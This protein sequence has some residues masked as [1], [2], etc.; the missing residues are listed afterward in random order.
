ML[1]DAWRDEPWVI[2]GAAVRAS[3]VCFAPSDNELKEH[4]LDGQGVD[5]IYTDLTAATE[6]KPGADLTKARRIARNRGVAFMGDTK[7]GPFDV[8]GELAREWLQEPMNPN[9]RPN[10]DVL[11][12][13]MNG[14]AITRRP[15]DKWIVD[16]GWT[17][18]REEAALYQAPFEHAQEHVHPMRQRNRRESYRR[19]WWRHVESRQGMW[20]ALCVRDRPA[21][22]SQGA[23]QR[24]WPT[25]KRLWT[26]GYHVRMQL[27]SRVTAFVLLAISGASG[28]D[29]AVDLQAYREG[30]VRANVD[31]SLLAVEWDDSSGVVW[32]AEFNRDP[33]EALLASVRAGDSAVLRDARPFYRVETGVRRK[34]WNAFFDYP[35]AHPDG[36]VAHFGSFR[37]AGLR[38]ETAGSRLRVRCRGFSAGP[39][40]GEITYTFFSGSR[41]VMQQATAATQA[42]NVAYYYDAGIEF[43]A[44]DQERPGRNM[45]TPL[46][47]FDTTGQLQRAVANGFQPERVPYRV[48]HRA[49]ATAAGQGSVAAMPAP[50]QYFLPRDFTSNLAHSWHRSW[51]GTVSLGIRQVRD[52]NWQFY[53][54]AN[55]P[56]GS[57]QAMSLF[58]VL[59]DGPPEE[60]LRSALRYTNSDRFPAL[61]GYKTVASHF[62]LAYTVQAV[63]QPGD[64]EPPFMRVLEPMGVDAAIIMDFHGDGHPRD[65]TELRLDELDSFF[66]MARRVSDRDFLLIP[67]EEANVHLGGH[68]ALVFPKPVYWWMNRPEGGQFQTEHSKRG[69][70][71]STADAREMLEL[72][73]REDGLMYQTHARTKGSTGFPDAIRDTEH[74]RDPR[75]FGA[76]WKAMPA[77]FSSPRLGERTLRLLD[78]MQNWELDKR[79][80]GEVDVFQFDETHEVYAH[81]NVNYVRADRLPRFDEYGTLLDSIRDGHFFVTTGEVLLPSWDIAGTEDE[82]EVSAQVRAT[83]PLRFAEIVWGDGAGTQRHIVDLTATGEFAEESFE[84]R[85]RA[86][87]WRWAR[88]AVWDV[89]ANGAFVN[90]VRR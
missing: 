5:A 38:V 41:L 56:P 32:R 71:Y 2:D 31:G 61:D 33:S 81:M 63:E 52:T 15:A 54:W 66:R 73:R 76:G 9:G 19:N 50:H 45:R 88:L 58:L 77:D 72:V 10:S 22:R 29:V 90:P 83:F 40:E 1:F 37:L 59:D 62:H 80:L 78:D 85:V 12:P 16:F 6:G 17:M 39:F 46:A 53:P 18:V 75:Y 4:R 43:E 36:T 89:A 48:R 86:P 24:L 42:Q 87:G 23:R 30:P 28:A 25:R 65:L 11:K 13:W 14:M 7:G 27:V 67:S 68:W 57:A 69:T 82:I 21:R 8:P 84:W 55:A 51:R 35:P 60:A 64:W 3:L 79:L 26:L 49:L 47:Y 44:P 74:F 34:G 70:V 20:K